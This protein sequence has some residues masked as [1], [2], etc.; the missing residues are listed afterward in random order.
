M[1]PVSLQIVPCQ[2]V[3]LFRQGAG[4]F[5]HRQEG[6]EKGRKTAGPFKTFAYAVA[7]GNGFCNRRKDIPF[8][9]LHLVFQ[10]GNGIG[11]S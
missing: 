6:K 11:D 3:E 1:K 4:Q 8:F 5:S 10:K 9:S 2:T 7:G